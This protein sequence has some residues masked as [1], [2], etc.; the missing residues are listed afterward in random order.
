MTK[1][2]LIAALAHAPDDAVIKIYD[3]IEGGWAP[4][5]LCEE[6]GEFERERLCWYLSA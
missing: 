2:E 4:V 5:A 1:A 3:D 6:A